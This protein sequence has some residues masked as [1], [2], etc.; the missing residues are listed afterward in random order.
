MQQEP[1]PELTFIIKLL[2]ISKFTD[3]LLIDFGKAC[4]LCGPFVTKI[5]FWDRSVAFHFDASTENSG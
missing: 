1:V 2:R 4:R 3:T 5:R